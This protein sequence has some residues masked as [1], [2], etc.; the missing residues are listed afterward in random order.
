MLKS[1]AAHLLSSGF[2]PLNPKAP[3]VFCCI[4]WLSIIFPVTS[5]NS[6]LRIFS[7]KSTCEPRE[8][9]LQDLLSLADSCATSIEKLVLEG[10]I[11]EVSLK[12]MLHGA[13]RSDDV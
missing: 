5:C 7:I 6:V 4:P 3:V 12:V 9:D 13:I 1:R 2:H 8:S 11:P 10:K